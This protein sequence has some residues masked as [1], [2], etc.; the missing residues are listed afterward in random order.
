MKPNTHFEV[1][2]SGYHDEKLNGIVVP[3]TYKVAQIDIILDSVRFHPDMDSA[4]L[5]DTSIN[6][7]KGEVMFYAFYFRPQGLLSGT[8]TFCTMYFTTGPNWDSSIYMVLD[9]FTLPS[10]QGLVYEDTS[11][12]GLVPYYVLRD[13]S[14]CP[15]GH[16]I[17]Q[18]I[19]TKTMNEN[20][21]LNF[22]VSA[23][24]GCPTIPTLSAV[25]LPLHS[26]FYDSGNGSGVFT[27]TPDF[28]QSGTYNVTFIACDT[29]GCDSETVQITVL[30][31]E[32]KRGD[33]NG[34]G[35]ITLQDIIYL[36]NYLFKQGPSPVPEECDG[37]ANNNGKINLSDIVYLINFL[38]KEGLPPSP[39]TCC[40]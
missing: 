6:R 36:I 8:D 16:S 27:F 19:S 14:S 35:Q 11:G 40:I 21:I 38:F 18:L 30:C 2:A 13:T 33:P 1:V 26:S 39:P 37:D 20:E 4:N 29:V 12:Y 9:T 3:L 34:N 32:T 25:D 15:F 28:T 7:T 5:R 10:G 22:R 24:K 17:I 31:S 23:Y